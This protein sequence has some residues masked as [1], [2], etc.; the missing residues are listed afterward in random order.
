MDSKSELEKI[1]KFSLLFSEIRLSG[2][3][4]AQT[5][6]LKMVSFERA[7]LTIF[8]FSTATIVVLLFSLDPLVKT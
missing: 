8:L 5:S 6:T 2:R 4:I 3:S 7:L 1:M